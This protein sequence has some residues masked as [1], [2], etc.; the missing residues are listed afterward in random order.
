MLAGGLIEDELPVDN[1]D[2]LTVSNVA[3]AVQQLT[4]KPA[5]TALLRYE[6]N[7]KDRAGAV[8]GIKENRLAALVEHG[9]SQ[10]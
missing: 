1:Y 7:H 9:I 10:N 6:Q 5:L 2:D 4:D 3:S 8:A